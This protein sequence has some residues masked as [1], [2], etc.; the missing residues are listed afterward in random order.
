M[1]EGVSLSGA[2][3]FTPEL[4]A[5][6]LDTLDEVVESRQ[7]ATRYYS[8]KKPLTRVRGFEQATLRS[9]VRSH[10]DMSA[11]DL[12]ARLRETAASSA[13]DEATGATSATCAARSWWSFSAPNGTRA[14]ALA[15]ERL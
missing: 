11:A 7:P 12:M 1:I 14:V 6:E 15:R 2:D 8:S 13:W 9:T 5:A 10:R 4:L 3:A